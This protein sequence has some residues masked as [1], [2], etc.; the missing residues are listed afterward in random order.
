MRILSVFGTRPEA[1]KMAPL[2][3]H[4][5]GQVEIEVC[6]TGQHRK[7]LDQ[8][9]EIFSIQPRYDLN[10]MK[11]NQ[12]LSSLAGEILIKVGELLQR[13]KYEWILVQG[14]TTTTMA[15]ALA[16]F[17][18]QVRVGHLEAGLRTY[19]LKS[20]FPEELNR[21]VT[22]RASSLHFAPTE[23]SRLN[24]VREG[25]PEENIH[26]TGNTVIDALYWV[27]K[28]VPAPDNGL[29]FEL[30]E[31]QMILVTGHRR[32]N[33]GHGFE[34]ICQALAQ[35]SEQLPEVQIVYPVHLNPN[36]RGPVYQLLGKQ[37]NIHLLGP[38]EYPLF[39]HLMSKAYLILTDSGG[40]QE[41]APSLGKPVLL[42]RDTTERPEAVES[43]NVQLVG[44]NCSGI[45][46]ATMNLQR[47]P[48]LYRKMATPSQVYGDGHA[49]Q[50]IAE[51]LLR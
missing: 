17:Y 28:N 47:D 22:S 25:F 48:E 51:L 45:V 6:V 26:V 32:E 43:G 36:V 27:L 24:L 13:Q 19:N 15:A 9:L 39:V 37:P 1:I 11:P 34:Q 3:L 14:D 33:F 41:E 10:L 7:M 5:Q 29:P 44:A 46:E 23:T 38:L 2:I 18:H 35:L 30:E 4:L 21:Q 42:M 40:V 31:R 20:P 12:S 50:R 8:V 16:G 49:S